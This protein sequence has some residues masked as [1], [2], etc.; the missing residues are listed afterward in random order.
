MYLPLA[1]QFAENGYII[2]LLDI[3]GHGYSQGV[4]GHMPSSDAM[5]KDIKHFNEYVLRV[6]GINQKYIAMGHSLG[7]YVWINTL[8]SM[9][10]VNIDV[11]VLISGGIVDNLV[12]IKDQ[13]MKYIFYEKADKLKMKMFNRKENIS[14]HTLEAPKLFQKRFLFRKK[15]Y[16]YSMRLVLQ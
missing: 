15:N 5:A 3:R 10:N 7:T 12:K 16:Y 1:D 11:L 14:R 8:A 9:E 2:Y 13:F 4:S 6:E